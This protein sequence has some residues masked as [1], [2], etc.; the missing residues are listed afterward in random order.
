MIPRLPPRDPTVVSEPIVRQRVRPAPCI[1]S[2]PN[3][4][5]QEAC[6][7]GSGISGASVV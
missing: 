5:G 1:E 7:D 2:L 3:K 6:P 4:G